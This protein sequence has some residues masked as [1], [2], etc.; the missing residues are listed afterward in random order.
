ML[1]LLISNRLKLFNPFSDGSADIDLSSPNPIH[2]SRVNFARDEKSE[3]GVR[4]AL[5]P[6]KLL[7]LASGD[8]SEIGLP[9]IP[10]SIN[11]PSPAS[12]D[13]SVI[14]LSSSS[15]QPT[16]IKPA[17]GDTSVIR[18]PRNLMLYHF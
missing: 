16:W 10:I 4:Q 3:I 17:S 9:E 5:I 1:Q 7:K 13:K 6:C 2:L 18:F 12:G 14:S 11:F 8:T 15:N